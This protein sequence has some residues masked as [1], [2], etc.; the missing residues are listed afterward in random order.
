MS[1]YS[2][3]NYPD[4]VKNFHEDVRNKAID[5]MNE[6]LKEGMNEPGAIA[7]GISEAEEWAKDEGKPI[8]KD[9]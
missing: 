1:K 9:D 4:S 5:R 6:H 2:Y 3:D 8:K 7:K